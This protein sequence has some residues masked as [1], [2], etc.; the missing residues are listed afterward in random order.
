MHSPTS[1]PRERD[2]PTLEHLLASGELLPSQLPSASSWSPEKKLAAAVLGQALIEVRD[3]H[4]DPHYRRRIA[5]DLEWIGSDDADWPYAFV[6]LCE[7]L[8]LE[9]EYVRATVQRWL[10]TPSSPHRQVSVHRHAA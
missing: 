6:P 8:A 3:H 5:E 7:L 10:A 1:T 2:L 9:P 4:A